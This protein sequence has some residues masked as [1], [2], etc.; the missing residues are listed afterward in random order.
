MNKECT[1][2]TLCSTICKVE[3]NCLK[4]CTC[5][6]VFVLVLYINLEDVKSILM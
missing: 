4:M 2:A 3:D 6:C 5:C 1:A